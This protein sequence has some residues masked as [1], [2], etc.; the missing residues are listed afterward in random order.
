[1]I[2]M[3][4]AELGE[5]SANASAAISAATSQQRSRVKLTVCPPIM[6]ETYAKVRKSWNPAD[7]ILRTRR[8]RA[9]RERRTWPA[10]SADGERVSRLS[11]GV[12]ARRERDGRIFFS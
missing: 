9:A 8:F 10:H 12:P 1:M 2:Y 4:A 3:M 6:E 11:R 7:T 5:W